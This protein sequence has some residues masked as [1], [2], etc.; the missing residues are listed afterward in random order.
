[1]LNEFIILMLLNTPIGEKEVYVGKIPDC[2]YSQSVFERYKQKEKNA[3]G[4]ICITNEVW[5]HR[6][7]YLK[8]LTPTQAKKVEEIREVL[9]DIKP[10]PLVPLKKREDIKWDYNYQYQPNCGSGFKKE[11]R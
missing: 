4:Y 1:M 7:P 5:K 9:P 3:T 8:E 6:K 10:K 2:S 11:Y